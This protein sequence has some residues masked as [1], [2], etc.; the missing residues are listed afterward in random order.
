MPTSHKVLMIV[1]NLSVPVD[2]RVWR[3]A[4]T[5]RRHGFQVCVIC[6]KGEKRDQESYICIEG[7]HIYR[8]RQPVIIAK[9]QFGERNRVVFIHNRNNSRAFGF[10]KGQ[11]G[12]AG[13]QVL[14]ARRDVEEGQEH[15]G[16]GDPA[17]E[18]TSTTA[19]PASCSVAAWSTTCS[20]TSR[21]TSPRA[22]ATMLEPSLITRML[23]AG[24]F[25]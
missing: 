7:I 1:E 14:V 15:L 22:S 11:Q 20:T 5:L 19:S 23:T 18:V 13:V 8:Y 21:R 24:W 2:P 16:A 4:C 10:Q 3:E 25:G 12:L 9:F 17:R 6:P